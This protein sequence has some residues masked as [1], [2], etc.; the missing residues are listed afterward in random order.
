MVKLALLVPV[1]LN[2]L[3]ICDLLNHFCF[4]L[5]IFFLNPLY[6]CVTK[7]NKYFLSAGFFSH[8]FS[9]K[10]FGGRAACLWEE[11]DFLDEPLGTFSV[12]VLPRTNDESFPLHWYSLWKWNCNC[13]YFFVIF[14]S[15][16]NP[17]WVLSFFFVYISIYKHLICC[18]WSS[19]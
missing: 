15:N 10:H 13:F 3:F 19:N 18:S 14:F 7:L 17:C 1:Y 8:S 2:R 12:W 5:W 16:F 4:F 9:R 6:Q 11:Q